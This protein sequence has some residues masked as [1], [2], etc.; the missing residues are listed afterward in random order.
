MRQ[1]ATFLEFRECGILVSGNQAKEGTT[2]MLT[3]DRVSYRIISGMEDCMP[4]VTARFGSKTYNKQ[5][6][7]RRAAEN[8]RTEEDKRIGR[9]LKGKNLRNDF[10]TK[11]D[12]EIEI[13]NMGLPFKC[14][15][16]EMFWLL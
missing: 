2:D 15:V 4:Q 9:F 1:S 11:L 14:T 7:A 6:V 5:M 10:K 16:A 3:K 12:A 13:I 8:Q